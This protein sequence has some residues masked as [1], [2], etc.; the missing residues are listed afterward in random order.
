[1]AKLTGV[2]ALGRVT[3]ET[4]AGWYARAS[5][6]AL[7]ARYEPF[8]LTALEAALAG[9]ALVLGD[10]PSLREVWSDTALFVPADDH[11]ALE[12]ALKILIANEELRRRYAVRAR[13]RALRYT[14]QRMAAAYYS[15]Y[16]DLAGRPAHMRVPPVGGE[17]R[18]AL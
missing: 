6:Y 7:P 18:V 10:I 4:L 15:V 5:I 2:E 8:G 9:C 13:A 1:L 12:I 14:P 16:R 17:E 3:A 11:E